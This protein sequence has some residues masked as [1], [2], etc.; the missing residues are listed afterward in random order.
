MI[1]ETL[2]IIQKSCF[3]FEIYFLIFCYASLSSAVILISK[4]LLFN[5]RWIRWTL[6]C[7][8]WMLDIQDV[9]SGYKLVS[10][11][12]RKMRRRVRSVVVTGTLPH[13][14][15][16]Y[17]CLY[18]DQYFH[19]GENFCFFLHLNLHILNVKTLK[20][21]IQFIASHKKAVI[22]FC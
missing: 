9:N 5:F 8:S 6:T 17:H 12:R 18:L 19:F 10:R 16:I 1:Q 7:I 22:L 20:K 15:L 11:H 4:L 21:S 13:P 3:S 14:Q 2:W